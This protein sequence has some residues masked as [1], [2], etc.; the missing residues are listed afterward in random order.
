VLHFCTIDSR[1][2]APLVAGT[3]TN[4][5]V[6][7]STTDTTSTP[8]TRWLL[9]VP[10]SVRDRGPATYISA[11]ATNITNFNRRQMERA[12]KLAARGNLDPE[13][14]TPASDT[15]LDHQRPWSGRRRA[16]HAD[17]EQGNG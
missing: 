10:D 7:H 1:I 15:L 9:A 4:R 8:D 6:L 11:Y 2:C 5:G 13:K 16:F 12:D 14:L 17:V 3:S